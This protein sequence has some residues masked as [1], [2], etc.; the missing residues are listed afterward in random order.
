MYNASELD[1]LPT[2]VLGM[3]MFLNNVAL[4]ALTDETLQ[5]SD[6]PET[7]RFKL[8]VQ[9]NGI[10]SEL[11][12][13]TDIKGSASFEKKAYQLMGVLNK[14]ILKNSREYGWKPGT[15]AGEPVSSWVTIEIPRSLL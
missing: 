2:P 6:L 12:L 1:E 5:K 7:I 3:N 10:I 4:D 11:N 9:R 15:R 14:N 13:L 8:V